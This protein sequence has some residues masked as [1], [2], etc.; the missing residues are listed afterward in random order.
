VIHRSLSFAAVAVGVF[1][2][3]ALGGPGA[4]NAPHERVLFEDQFN[5]KLGDGWSWVYEDKE[6]WRIEG[7][8]LQIRATGGSSFRQEH[9]G[10]NYLLR[11]PPDVKTGEL[12]VEA[13]IENKPTEQWEHAGLYW[14]Y[15]DDHYVILNK[16]RN[17]YEHRTSIM[18][19]VEKDGKGGPSFPDPTYEAEGVWLRFRV[20]GTHIVGE[21][22]AT[23]TDPWREVGHGEL[24]VNGPPRVGFHAGYAPKKDL[25]RWASFSHFKM[26]ELAKE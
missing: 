13:Y 16:E 24:P 20:K 15:D 18:F 21:Y 22:R 26:A 12:S 6:N 9:N 8:K 23:P 25:N 14:F 17:N 11:T 4:G 19:G 2:S 7:G 5:G 1:L 10:K 3:I